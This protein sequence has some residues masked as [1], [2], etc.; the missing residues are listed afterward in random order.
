[1]TSDPPRLL[2]GK[3]DR[4]E[5]LRR[6]LDAAQQDVPNNAALARLAARL[7]IRG[8]PD[9]G[10]T[11]G[12]KL[13]GSVK[14]TGSAVGAGASG[15]L[16]GSAAVGAGL[17]LAVVVAWFA[18]SVAPRAAAPIE[19]TATVALDRIA[20]APAPQ[21]AA[22]SAAPAVA[23]TASAVA[24]PVAA[25]SALSAPSTPS[26]ARVDAATSAPRAAGRAAEH[27]VERATEPGAESEASL[28]QR[29]QDAIASEPARALALAEAH[30]AHFPGGALGQEREMIAVAA[31]ANQGRA[32]EARARARRLIAAFPRSAYRRRLEVLLPGL[33]ND[34]ADQKNQTEVPSTR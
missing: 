8:G 31:L 9:G 28:L 27:T 14:A 26:A 15:S 7:P 23:P 4:G 21:F 5:A 1:M 6:A 16:L 12:E 18:T 20:P 10:S 32:P 29:A 24:R 25:P 30:A 22:A 11:G 3:G 2:E 34:I 19:A 33:E 13:T 17:G